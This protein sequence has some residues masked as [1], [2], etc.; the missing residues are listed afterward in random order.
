MAHG[1]VIRQFGG[2]PVV[3]MPLSTLTADV[4]L[5]GE[6]PYSYRLV[7]L[8]G[9]KSV[10]FEQPA[11]YCAYVLEANGLPVQINS[12]RAPADHFVLGETHD[13]HIHCEA[14]EAKILVA[15]QS[16]ASCEDHLSLYS[17]GE[18]KKVEKPWGH[19]IWLTGDPSKLFA[20]KRILLKAGNQTSLQYHRFKRETNFI[21]SGSA[22]LHFNPDASL[23]AD[24]V[25]PEAIESVHLDGPFV[26]DVYPGSVH[27]L[28]ALTDML[29]YEVSTPELDDV[30]R[31]HDETGRSHGR[32]HHEHG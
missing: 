7:W 28:E 27:R 3:A 12:Q 23:A 22:R 9:G 26:A 1:K 24:Q 10:R 31:I 14:G 25:R 4:V 5:L 13:M 32:I 19:E 17:L 15:A 11:R 16:V 6:K 2:I 30:I 21:V 8:T 29:L 18:A 20:F